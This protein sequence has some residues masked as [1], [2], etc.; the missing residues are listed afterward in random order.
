MII[1][2]II[3]MWDNDEGHRRV[4]PMSDKMRDKRRRMKYNINKVVATTART[5]DY[6]K[7]DDDNDDKYNNGNND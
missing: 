6:D 1:M 7:K 4:K 3:T 2:T 5:D